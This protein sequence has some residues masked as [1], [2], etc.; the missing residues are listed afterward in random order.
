[1]MLSLIRTVSV[2]TEV[3]L[4]TT[5]KLPAILTSPVIEP[6]YERNTVLS[7]STITVLFASTNAVVMPS[8]PL[9]TNAS[10]RRSSVPVPTS[11]ETSNVV[12]TFTVET[13][14]RRPL[15]STVTIG[16]CVCPPYVPD[17]TPVVGREVLIV[18]L[19]E[20]LSATLPSVSPVAKK[21]IV[22]CHALAVRALP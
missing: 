5:D 16:I 19:E 12:A 2:I 8:L 1:M 22:F 14:V 15:V 13:L 7:T 9:T 20:P 3:V 4:P 6:P 10:V 11:P 17:V 21:V 18:T